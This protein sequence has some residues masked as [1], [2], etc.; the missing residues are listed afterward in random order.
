MINLPMLAE[1]L[2]Q[3]G[4]MDKSFSGCSRD[5]INMI[6]TAVFSSVEPA[7]MPASYSKPYIDSRGDLVIGFDV[8]PDYRWWQNG[9]SIYETLIELEA[10]YS[11]AKKYVKCTEQQWTDAV[12]PF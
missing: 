4:L 3:A 10:P 6:I 5:E 1:K 12:A 11:V 7:D 9:K 8:H 2:Q